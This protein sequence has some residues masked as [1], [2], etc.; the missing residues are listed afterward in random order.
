[1]ARLSLGYPS[2]A[3]EVAM[4]R[5]HEGGDRVAEVEAVATAAEVLALQDAARR[6]YASDA[7]RT[8]VVSLLARTREDPRIELGA[9]P[10]AGLLL[11]RAAKARALLHGRDHALVDDVQALAT[12]VLAHRIVLAPEAMETSGARIVA[13]ALAT[14]PA[15]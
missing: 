2:A 14:T 9:S 5:S 15:L 8:Y 11:P 3:G 7:L 12:V 10:R 6:V 13:D 1:M 4:L